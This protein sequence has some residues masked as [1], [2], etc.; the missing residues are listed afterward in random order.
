MTRPNLRP[1]AARFLR[2][3]S[4]VD[5]AAVVAFLRVHAAAMGVLAVVKDALDV[6]DGRDPVRLAD[7]MLRRIFNDEAAQGAAESGE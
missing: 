6:D 4:V 7:A 5:A 3:R 1:I 2:S